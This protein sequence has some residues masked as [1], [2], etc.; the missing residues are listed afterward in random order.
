[1]FGGYSNPSS[2]IPAGAGG[3]GYNNPSSS[4]NAFGNS[5]S[6]A[7]PGY[8]GTSYTQTTYSY[9]SGGKPATTT[10][11]YSYGQPSAGSF[12]ASFGQPT[13][14]GYTQ[15]SQPIST[16]GYGGYTQ[17]SQPISTGGYGGYSQPSTTG[18]YGQ[19][20]IGGYSQPSQPQPSKPTQP[21]TG[22]FGALGGIGYGV[23]GGGASG[24]T[25]GQTNYSPSKPK[26]N[27]DEIKDLSRAG[28]DMFSNAFAQSATQAKSGYSELLRQLKASGQ[29]YKDLEF[30]AELKSL[31]GGLSD[32]EL[33][34]SGND[35]NWRSII[36]ARPEEFYG[37]GFQVFQGNI[38]PN[39]IKQ[40]SLGDCYFL[41][42]IAAIAEKPDRIKRLFE[43]TEPNEQG[44]YAVRVCDVGTWQTIIL[45]DLIPCSGKSR[46]PIFTKGNGNEL[47][48]LLLEKAWAKIYG[49]YARIEA[50][51]TRECLHDLTGAPTKYYL[52]G[53][54]SK[55]NEEIWTEIS[56]GE[57]K[58][59]V[60]TCGSGD[61]FE[62]ADLMSSVGLVGSHAYSLLAAMTIRDKYGRDVRLVKLRNP[63]GQ[64]EWTG[65][66]SDSSANWTPELKSQLRIEKRD[67]GIFYMSFQDM[68]K[69]FSDIQICKVHDEYKYNSVKSSCDHRH[70]TFFKLTVRESGHYYITINQESKR[71]H[72]EREN[73]R[74]SEVSVVFGR[75]TA[76]G[77]EYVEG[78]QKADK[79]VW[80]DGH[81]D[82]GEYIVY[83]KIHWNE[84]RTK[85]FSISSYGVGTV[86]IQQVPQTFCPEFIEK[87]YMSKGRQSQKKED[88]QHCGVRNC[89]RAV[90]LTDDGFGFIYY[91]NE[92]NKTLE[93]EIYFKAMEGLK[94]KK[95]FTGNNYKIS[96]PP[97]QERIVITKV[98]PNAARIRQA[99]TERARFV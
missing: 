26:L 17:P 42:T 35:L 36:W 84:Q 7:P 16:G 63:W 41:S 38:E 55:K 8:G 46:Q 95:P 70:A 40:G 25:G 96:V 98:L 15:P 37:R 69:Y 54:D 88:Y 87:V 82:A 4:Q 45:D 3:V 89:F 60:M 86:D 76:N 61:F 5:F 11:S 65:E 90:E 79:E 19:P 23:S 31:T 57:K 85:E 9:S 64:G 50:G 68:L 73:Y 51:L 24:R 66:W 99:F 77:Y 6:N 94:F 74:Y 47:W 43:S 27:Q 10:T 62:G 91:K 56:N 58:D 80:T 52:T 93:E 59:F 12:G 30:P 2:H 20:T 22:G 34:Q 1:M 33:A 53:N 14:G 49:S 28:K 78:I 21:S 97:G 67:D 83:V 29:K 81:M 92:S 44:C 39:D 32:Y 48:V 72:A 75:K 71:K 18:G 13:V